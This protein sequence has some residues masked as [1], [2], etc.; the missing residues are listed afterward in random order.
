VSDEVRPDQ[1][2]PALAPDPP[3]VGAE[4][5]EAPLYSGVELEDEDGNRWVPRQQAV[6]KD[7]VMGTGEFADPAT[8]PV[9][10]APGD[11]ADEHEHVPDPRR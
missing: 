8:A 6:G 11:D 7:A 5:P 2:K 4:D 3:G 1:T 10:P 9:G